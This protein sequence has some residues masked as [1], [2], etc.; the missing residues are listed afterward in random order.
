MAPLRSYL[1]S[2]AL[3]LLGLFCGDW[4]AYGLWPVVFRHP[5]ASRSIPEIR[6]SM[7]WSTADMPPPKSPAVFVI[8]VFGGSVA[9]QLAMAWANDWRSIEESVALSRAVGR[10]LRIL[11]LAV[12]SGDQPGQYNAL[13][14]AHDRIDVA[15]FVDGFNERHSVPINGEPGCRFM[16]RFWE[17][18]R[19]SPEELWQ[20]VV[21]QRRALRAFA[22]SWI[23]WPLRYSGLFKLYLFKWGVDAAADTAQYGR[24]L[25]AGI[26]RSNDAAHSEER[27]ADMW[28]E[29]ARLSSEYA[30]GI[31]MPLHMFVQPNLHLDGAKPYSP[32]EETLRREGTDLGP[33]YALLDERVAKLEAQGVVVRS[34]AQ[35]FHSIPETL[36][37]DS[38][39]HVSDHGSDIMAAV[40][41]RTILENPHP[42]NG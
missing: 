31:H 3:V 32:E 6:S 37:V 13:H 23:W 21:E 16:K 12:L 20:H 14:L 29:C 36:Y 38:C 41:S 42:A 18:N 30:R 25:G 9:S 7:R 5:F 19:K 22:D 1:K 11:D 15:V 24:T 10:P 2:L 39:C 28:A 27:Q 33:W 34:L 4:I 40:I 8:G 26:S 17:Q 35:V